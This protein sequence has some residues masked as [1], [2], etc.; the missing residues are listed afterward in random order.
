M[1]G[2]NGKSDTYAVTSPIINII[3]ENL[4]CKD[5]DSTD[6]TLTHDED[7]RTSTPLPTKDEQ[8]KT[9]RTTPHP[10]AKPVTP[11]R[12]GTAAK[13]EQSSGTL[14]EPSGMRKPIIWVFDQ[15]RHKPACAANGAG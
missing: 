13:L 15:V 7:C 8:P 3:A 5:K 9:F 14:Y 11:V 2:L 12:E 1:V 10:Q 6:K 4:V